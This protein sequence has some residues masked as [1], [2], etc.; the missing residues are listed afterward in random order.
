MPT[1]VRTQ[2]P[3]FLAMLGLL[4]TFSAG[5]ARGD[6]D[7]GGLK[8]TPKLAQELS[9]I[10]GKEATMLTVEFAPGYVSD[11]HRHEAHTFVYVLEGRIEMQV[12]GGPL[13]KLKPGDAFYENPEDVH[14]V[15]RN[16]SKTKPAKFLV[17]LVKNKGAAPALPPQK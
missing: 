17:L 12:E 2:F 11:S 8:I 10:P 3:V 7:H 16:A 9:D 1:I 15:A 5:P 6:E 4:A 14:T 13:V